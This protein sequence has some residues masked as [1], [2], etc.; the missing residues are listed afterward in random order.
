MATTSRSRLN[1]VHA[2]VDE[3]RLGEEASD[4]ATSLW[5]KLESHGLND[6]DAW[7]CGALMQ[8]LALAACAPTCN[9]SG[10]TEIIGKISQAKQSVEA[11]RVHIISAQCSALRL[12]HAV[13]PMMVRPHVSIAPYMSVVRQ[14][15]NVMD[16]RNQREEILKICR[17]VLISSN[18]RADVETIC[19]EFLHD[20]STGIRS[21]AIDGLLSLAS[22]S[23]VLPR[24]L[25]ASAT[26]LLGD[27]TSFRSA[28]SRVAALRLLRVVAL[29]HRDA[30]VLPSFYAHA[31]DRSP[32]VRREVAL[33]LRYFHTVAS[34]S[35]LGQWLLKTP[36]EDGQPHVSTELLATGVLLSLLE[37]QHA[38]VLTEASRTIVAIARL[39]RDHLHV[40]ALEKAITAHADLVHTR[41][42]SEKLTI[43]LSLASLLQCH[44][45][46]PFAFTA[47]QMDYMFS[48]PP[49]DGPHA[50]ALLSV[51][52]AS[53]VENLLHANR[54]VDFLAAASA[55]YWP[56]A[57]A[58]TTTLPAPTPLAP[59]LQAKMF[60]L[61]RQ[62]GRGAAQLLGLDAAL[63]DRLRTLQHLTLIREF[64]APDSPS[65]SALFVSATAKDIQKQPAQTGNVIQAVVL[66]PKPV[67]T[68]V[69]GWQHEVPVHALVYG[70]DDPT[71]LAIKIVVR[72]QEPLRVYSHDVL[73]RN[74]S[75]LDRRAWQVRCVISV[76]LMAADTTVEAIVCTKT[77][78]DQ[79]TEM[80]PPVVVG[81]NQPLK[82]ALNM[83]PIHHQRAM[84]A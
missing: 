18:L 57:T 73:P 6:T 35:Q 69:P 49:S 84:L 12:L 81:V 79:V 41:A 43:T 28:S 10:H 71:S 51:L 63:R 34:A 38:E 50:A 59:A 77:A 16:E 24:S 31:M 32:L 36:L 55:L 27:A 11:E 47:E 39:R 68:C 3:I 21:I 61:T 29:Q 66:P 82:L 44:V 40:A 15:T 80:G 65:P 64:T 52:A 9:S 62:I 8:R 46:R 1:S 37:D 70:A 78:Q 75:W 23:R 58:A 72:G 48:N 76:A 20:E 42:L 2:L 56:P 22:S 19:I 54:T 30:S 83:S 74:I 67:A 14:S 5:E 45:P 4:H 25:I 17:D 60:Q 26:S 53:A 13:K 33:S 7:L